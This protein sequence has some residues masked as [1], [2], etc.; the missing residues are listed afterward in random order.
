[1]NNGRLRLCVVSRSRLVSGAR[2][3]GMAV[4]VFRCGTELCDKRLE[5]VCQAIRCDMA[6][7]MLMTRLDVT[8]NGCCKS[9]GGIAKTK[10][11]R[12]NVGHR[13]WLQLI[14]QSQLK[15]HKN[16]I[17]ESGK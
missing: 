6:G 16:G 13:T 15:I 9:A 8:C 11:V 2:S 17:L 5:V 3:L 4:G 10:R 12:L 1:M 7:N 14:S